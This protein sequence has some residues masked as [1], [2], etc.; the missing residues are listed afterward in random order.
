MLMRWWC[1]GHIHRN[2]EKGGTKSEMEIFLGW[3]NLSLPAWRNEVLV[4][5]PFCLS[6]FGDSHYKDKTV[7]FMFIMGIHM[8]VRWHLYMG[9]VTKLQLSCYLVMLAKPGNKTAT[10]SW[11]DPYWNGRQTLYYCS[12]VTLSQTFYP[13]AVKLL[14]KSYN[15]T[16]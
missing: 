9:Q 5:I 10:V 14:N 4:S 16:G 3:L 6:S 12:D 8:L 15:A 13:V 11:P 7:V 1:S 2:E